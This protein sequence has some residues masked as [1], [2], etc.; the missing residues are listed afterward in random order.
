MVLDER[1]IDDVW[2]NGPVTSTL[3]REALDPAAEAALV[4]EWEPRALRVARYITRRFQRTA[5][6][7]DL[8]QIARL[9]LLQAARRFDPRR[10]C[11]FSTYVYHTIAGHLLHYLRD[12]T[13]A[14]RIPRRWFDL[15]SRL[16]RLAAEL[17][18][19]LEREPTVLELAERLGV[20]EEEVA[21]ALGAQE[22]CHP[23]SLDVIWEGTEGDRQ[24]AVAG[25]I[26]VEDPLLE[27][28]E[29][30]LALQQLLTA[31]PERL[32]ELIRL[33]Y[34]QG[35]SQQEVGR[36]LGV[37]QMQ[38]SR[39]ERQALASLRVDLR[40]AIAA[41]ETALHEAFQ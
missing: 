40:R 7:E 9:G 35:L 11:Q 32:S 41:G 36:R 28:L 13:P 26:G 27:T 10:N 3:G 21:G 1:Q 31:L 33:R 16:E 20:S 30:R 29:R 6:Q 5:E 24:G 25:Q 18:Q 22:F 12:H 4:R 8:D 39:L 14:L 17:V 38:V 15:R 34:F 2:G 19:V 23:A 37:S